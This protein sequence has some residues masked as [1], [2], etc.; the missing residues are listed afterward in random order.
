ML[1]SAVL[2]SAPIAHVRKSEVGVTATKR[3][4]SCPRASESAHFIPKN[5]AFRWIF[6][7][8]FRRLSR[9]V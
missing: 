8:G 9:H 2:L 3:R 5:L 4:C 7:C 6:I 1:V